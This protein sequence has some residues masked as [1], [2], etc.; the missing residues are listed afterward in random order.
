M[1]DFKD[2]M[3][4]EPPSRFAQQAA[5]PVH[6]VALENYKGILLCDR[7][8][9]I[10]AARGTQGGLQRH[11][12]DGG[13]G[14]IPPFL[15]SGKPEDPHFGIQ[16]STES[17][18]KLE[19]TRSLRKEGKLGGAG[20]SATGGNA[21]L[22]K[23]RQW[24]KS[25]AAA[26]KSS[27]LND[28][29][30]QLELEAKLARIREKEAESRRQAKEMKALREQQEA[31]KASTKLNAN[32]L[33]SL[34]ESNSNKGLKSTNAVL[35]ANKAAKSKAKA[36]PKW[37]MTEEEALDAEL[38]AHVGLV[39]FARGLD[40]SKFIE[41]YEVKEA[42]SIMRDRVKELAA[43]QH[44]N[45]EEVVKQSQDEDEDD[46]DDLISMAPS[47]ANTVAREEF[48]AAATQRR[49]ERRRQ[50]KAA[51]AEAAN[52]GLHDQAWN[53]NTQ[54]GDMLRQSISADAL[55]LAEK[56]LVSTQSLQKVHTK[57]SLARLLQRCVLSGQDA[58]EAMLRS[59][60]AMKGEAQ[61]LST[62]QPV[63]P[64]LKT[65]ISAE[66]TGLQ[67]GATSSKRILTDLRRAKDKTQNLPYMYRCPSL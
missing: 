61:L 14:G 33:A 58:T 17:R 22:S 38:E 20:G 27:K 28:A 24:L 2:V 50:R 52:G 15:P 43:A 10:K 19:L 6:A 48:R 67:D 21:A 12:D 55:A 60:N 42:L 23:H 63:A 3:L 36:K 5:P 26:V 47:D 35:Q 13:N 49:E 45:L 34:D 51:A 31:E 16:P 64:P 44:I 11:P 4:S 39:E 65:T 9:H 7:P 59:A 8:V 62:G 18:T 46:E 57:Q 1:E 40:Y 66:A 56:L 37:A 29:E 41:D 32:A 30:R 54:V 53:N 25:F